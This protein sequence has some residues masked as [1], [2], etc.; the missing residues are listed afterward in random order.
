[1]DATSGYIADLAQF[2]NHKISP[3]HQLE[4]LPLLSGSGSTLRLSCR[5]CQRSMGD[6]LGVV[7]CEKV[8]QPN[9]IRG[10]EQCVCRRARKSRAVKYM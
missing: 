1:M 2:D 4:H 9:V 7:V 8:M 10:K 3:S 5:Y 6:T